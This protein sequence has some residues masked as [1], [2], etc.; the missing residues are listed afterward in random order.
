MYARLPDGRLVDLD[1]GPNDSVRKVKEEVQR[2]K[3]IP[4][5]QQRMIYAEQQLKDE[6]TMS[7]YGFPL[8]GEVLQ[9]VLRRVGGWSRTVI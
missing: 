3:E 1:V 6:L 7:D 4:V 2:K 9:V 8:D 5:E